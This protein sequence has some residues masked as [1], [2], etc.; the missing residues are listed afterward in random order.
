[1]TKVSSWQKL[2]SFTSKMR[3]KSQNLSIIY[4]AT[5][6]LLTINCKSVIVQERLRNVYLSAYRINYQH[7]QSVICCSQ[8]YIFFLKLC[9]VVKYATRVAKCSYTCE[10][11]GCFSAC[12]SVCLSVCNHF[13]P[14]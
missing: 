13:F 1:M 9:Y 12:L 14:V 3:K 5:D 4:Y 8:V 2:Q 7:C 10:C 11:N 6:R